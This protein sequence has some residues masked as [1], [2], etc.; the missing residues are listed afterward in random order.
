MIVDVDPK[1][2]VRASQ[3][4]LEVVPNMLRSLA[5]A[6][7]TKNA[8]VHRQIDVDDRARSSSTK[9]RAVCDSG[10]KL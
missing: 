1:I 4:R 10:T 7:T 2:S 5:Q 9:R 6:P 3:T 8:K